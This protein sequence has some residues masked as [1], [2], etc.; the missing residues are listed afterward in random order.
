MVTTHLLHWQQQ[1]QEQRNI[2]ALPNELISVQTFLICRYGSA[3]P[4]QKEKLKQMQQPG[5]DIY[6]VKHVTR[7]I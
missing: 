3:K 5:E 4:K 2:W 1:R 6:D 7:R